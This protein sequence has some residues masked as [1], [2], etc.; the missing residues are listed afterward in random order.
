MV[1][2]GGGACAHSEHL[3]GPAPF[4]PDWLT[5]ADV[6]GI[7]AAWSIPDVQGTRAQVRV[8][9]RE[10]VDFKTTLYQQ[11]QYLLAAYLIFWGRLEL[12]NCP[13]AKT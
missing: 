6:N 13:I 4:S 9:P 3:V 1:E 12:F 10:A 7:D 5:A 11:L 2:V 8:G